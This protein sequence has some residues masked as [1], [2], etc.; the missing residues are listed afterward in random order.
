M[1]GAGVEPAVQRVLLLVEFLAA[2]VGAGEALWHQLH[3]LLLEPDVGAV[4][5]E[6]L[7]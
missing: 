3:G 5:I 2:A 4:L 1:G 6:Q 7:G